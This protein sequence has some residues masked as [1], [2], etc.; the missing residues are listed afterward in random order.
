MGDLHG[1]NTLE[2][3]PQKVAAMEGNW[4]TKSNVPLVLFAIPD[5]DARQ[6]RH[7]VSIPNL[8]SI[9]LTHK[10]DEVVPGLNDF[11]A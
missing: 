1:L 7:E 11:V 6:N 8:A 5:E 10:A 4:E 2:H 9:I 3:Q